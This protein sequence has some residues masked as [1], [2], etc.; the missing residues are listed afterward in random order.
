MRQKHWNQEGKTGMTDNTA[1]L[2]VTVQG[3]AVIG[4]AL[5]CLL[6]GISL[7]LLATFGVI[8]PGYQ[9]RFNLVVWLIIA[10]FPVLV[11]FS[12]FPGS[13]ISGTIQ[14]FSFSGAIAAFIFIWWYGSRTAENAGKLDELHGTIA[15]LE[16]DKTSLQKHL[17]DLG[18]R[19]SL[20][21]GV[22]GRY[23]IKNRATSI[24]LCTGNLSDVRDFDI[25]VNS[26]NTEMQMAR[27]HDQSV[28]ATIR[29]LG[30]EKDSAGAVMKD[31]I[32]EALM[33]AMGQ[34]KQV[35]PGTVLQTEAGRLRVSNNVRT[36]LHAAA[37]RGQVGLGYRPIGNVHLCVTNAL[38]ATESPEN[39]EFESIIFPLFGTGTAEGSRI[40]IINSLIENAIRYVKTSTDSSLKRI[41]FIALYKADLDAC[42]A[43]LD[44]AKDLK[45]E[46]VTT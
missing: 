44:N 22:A 23:A 7:Y 13:T 39:R 27:F 9:M 17:A 21:S 10:L 35:M 14:S 6:S 5:L 24:W 2:A 37:V 30:S 11:I 20:P 40:E 3:M 1:G 46:R 12:L 41:G 34:N 25:W 26:E 36:I 16:G 31:V 32:A 15:A 28:S 19:T 43:A 4:V 45:K 38:R 18:T 29:Y 33:A 8:R 42:T